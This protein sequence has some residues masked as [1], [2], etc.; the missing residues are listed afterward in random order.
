MSE[1]YVPRCDDLELAGFDVELAAEETWEALLSAGA[2]IEGEFT[3][4][5]GLRATIKTDAET[6]YDDPRQLDVVLGHFAAFP[7]VQDADALLYVP[8]GM[9]QFVTLLGKEMN[10]PVID[11]VRTPGATSK[12][13][14]MFQTPEDEERALAARVPVIGEDIVSTLGSVA[15]MRKLLSPDQPVHSLSILLRDTVDPAYQAGL[16]DHYLVTREIPT[17]KEDFRR[18]I[19]GEAA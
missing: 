11:A 14:F 7:C 5:S 3:F 13:D 15:A 8:D 1:L 2:F 12:Y 17:D 4:A 16:T 10:K 18:M 19:A 9:R 6:L